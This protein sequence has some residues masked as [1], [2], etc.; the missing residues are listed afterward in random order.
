MHVHSLICYNIQSMRVDINLLALFI[1]LLAFIY[2]Y[3]NSADIGKP[4][5]TKLITTSPSSS[6]SPD[7]NSRLYVPSKTLM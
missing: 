2:D 3:N 6:T 7:T 4:P 1:Y 5:K